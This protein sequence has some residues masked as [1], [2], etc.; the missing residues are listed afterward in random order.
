MD[1]L[2]P[3]LDA[4]PEDALREILLLKQQERVLMTRE[5]AAEDFMSYVHHV[6]ES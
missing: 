3:N 2:Q 5:R 4:V 1:D 6:Y